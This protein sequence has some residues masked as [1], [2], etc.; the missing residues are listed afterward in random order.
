MAL[1]P[2]PDRQPFDYQR[3]TEDS[4][5]KITAVRGAL[6]DAYAVLLVAVPECAERTLAIRKLEECSMWANKAIVFTQDGES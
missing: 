2:D 5:G 4:V 6:R 1:Y 3:P